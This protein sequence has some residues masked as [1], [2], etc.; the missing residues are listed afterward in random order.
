MTLE[1]LQKPNGNKPVKI[2]GLTVYPPW[3]PYAYTEDQNSRGLK[4]LEHIVFNLLWEK[5]HPIV[6]TEEEKAEIAKIPTKADLDKA[7]SARQNSI[8]AK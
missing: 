2:C 8:S 3:D 4:D 1:T 7:R 5:E 6:L